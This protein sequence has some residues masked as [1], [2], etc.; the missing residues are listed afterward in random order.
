MW[1]LCCKD[2]KELVSIEN[3]EEVSINREKPIVS[4]I[5]EKDISQYVREKLSKLGYPKVGDK[6]IVLHKVKSFAG[7]TFGRTDSKKSRNFT[8]FL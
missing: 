6:N 4:V 3:I 8:A 1:W 7:C 5:L 2:L